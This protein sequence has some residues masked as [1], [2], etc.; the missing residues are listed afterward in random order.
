MVFGVIHQSRP[1]RTVI[2]IIVGIRRCC[3]RNGYSVSLTVSPNVIAFGR[4]S[5]HC[6]QRGGLRPLWRSLP[7]RPECG[8]LQKSIRD[9]NMVPDG[10]KRMVRKRKMMKACSIFLG[11]VLAAGCQPHGQMSGTSKQASASLIDVI[12]I[13]GIEL[14]APQSIPEC[15]KSH[16]R[17]TG[18]GCECPK[19]PI[20]CWTSIA[21]GDSLNSSST[22][23]AGEKHDGRVQ[24]LAGLMSLI[25]LQ[26]MAT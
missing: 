2:I 12:D 24:V 18:I 1:A 5:R 7:A 10:E 16:D 9:G 13:V 26:K 6:E 14:G 15:A 17:L 21:T 11:S 22:Y 3:A 4:S 19:K 8:R 23:P 20:P 25:V